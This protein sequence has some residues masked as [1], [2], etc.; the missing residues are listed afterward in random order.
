MPY[1]IGLK[2]AKYS[3]LPCVWLSVVAMAKILIVLL[4][5][6]VCSWVMIHGAYWQCMPVICTANILWKYV[7]KQ[8]HSIWLNGAIYCEEEVGGLLAETCLLGIRCRFSMYSL[9]RL[10][11]ECCAE[12][13][14]QQ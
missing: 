1:A 12:W 14:M 13:R 9:I 3:S 2:Y 5:H 8:R 7:R 6:I 11:V 4:A 10:R